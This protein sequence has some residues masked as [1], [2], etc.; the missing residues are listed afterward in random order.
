MNIRRPVIHCA[1]ALLA[2]SGWQAVARA[3]WQSLGPWGGAAEIVRAIPGEKDSV[4]AATGTGFLYRS[5][6]GGASWS[7]VPF[8]AQSAGV[9]H[10]LEIDPR[11]SAVWFAGME[12]SWPH[13]S[14]VYKTTDSGRSWTL[15]P[16]TKGIAIWSLSFSPSNPGVIAAGAG[17]GVYLTRDSG[18]TWN[19]ISPPED[20]ELKPVVSLAFD[21]S[22]SAVLYAGTTHLPWRT[23]DGGASWQSIHTGMI[24]DS[25]VFNI[26][27]DPHRPDRVLASACSGA[28]QSLDA[29]DHWTR[30]NTPTTAFR[31]YF[32]ALDPHHPD[33]LF[34]GTSDGLVKSIDGGVKWRKVSAHVVR[35]IAFDPFVPGRIFFAST[36]GG[37]MVSSD[38]GDTLRESNT[39]FA[40]RPFTSLATSGGALY[41]SGLLDLYPTNDLALRWQNVGTG[42]GNRNLLA[43]SAA[44]DAPHTLWGAR[45]RGLFESPDGGKTWQTRTGLPDG[46]RV[47]AVLARAQGVVL[48]GT[49]SGLFRSDSTSAWN[50]MAAG[51]VDQLRNTGSKQIVALGAS[52]ALV[53]EDDGISWQPCA[54]PAPGLAWYGLEFDRADPE[55]AL[56][57]TSRGLFRS[58]DACRSWTAITG[59]LEQA[60]VKAVLFHPTRP[61]EVFAAQGGRVFRSTDAGET[62]LPLDNADRPDLWPSSLLLLDSAPDRLFALVPGR[63]LFSTTLP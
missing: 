9:L 25:D 41:L 35:S 32:T 55:I 4:L 33:T 36:D 30:L 51:P 45:Y 10:A 42:P 28:Y 21:P 57:A 48:A 22:D 52:A 15:L 6:N 12:G 13:T 17:S 63:G 27:V 20:P 8:P 37:L 44:P 24:D 34:A 5:T 2:M 53:S 19:L 18:E 7:N 26:E 23:G 16:A 59:G 58:V 3:S 14:G 46:I 49:D 11:S 61:A 54:D 56:A 29:A 50:R 62:W 43:L 47:K 38:A 31:T 39:G 60:T 1:A 40:N